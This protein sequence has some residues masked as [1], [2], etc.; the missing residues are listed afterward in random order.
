MFRL[1]HGRMTDLIATGRGEVIEVDASTN[2]PIINRSKLAHPSES[3]RGSLT[4]LLFV[5][6]WFYILEGGKCMSRYKM[7]R[8]GSTNRS[9]HRVIWERV[10]GPIPPGYVIHHIDGN[11]RNNDL[12]NLRMMTAGEHSSLHHKLREEGKD[13]VDP[14]D[15]EVIKH[16]NATS[17][18]CARYYAKNREK[19]RAKVR[20]KYD[21]E[22]AR[23][24]REKH[25]DWIKAY[26]GAH[27]EENIAYQ[28]AYRAAH[29]EE[30]AKK[31][32]ER[33][34]NRKNRKTEGGKRGRSI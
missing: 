17:I 21:P 4:V 12:S 23:I 33:N 29:R 3:P 13:P 27:R 11:S 6:M 1:H 22:K 32:R 24:R 2:D 9:E 10:N 20:A 30:L 19:I 26:R 8:Y 16:R 15:P 34:H 7:V 18:L 28:R 14:N 5:T 31:D 25:Q